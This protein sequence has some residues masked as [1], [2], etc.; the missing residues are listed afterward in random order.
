MSRT[1][2]L[3]RALDRSGLAPSPVRSVPAPAARY[4]HPH[5]LQSRLGQWG[6][7]VYSFR[8]FTGSEP[9]PQTPIAAYEDRALDREQLA[10][11]RIEY[12]AARAM[13]SHARLRAQATPVLRE[14][15][16]LW[17]AWEAAHTALTT[18]FRTFWETPDGRWR[19][20][21]LRL[22][23]AEN[24]A[25]D[26]ARAWDQVA[27][28][29]AA[30]ADAQVSAAGYE[31]ELELAAVAAEAGTDVSGWHVAPASEYGDGVWST[32]TPLVHKVRTEI[33]A[34]RARLRDVA[35]LAGDRELV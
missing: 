17:A 29:L 4:H 14:A 10:E 23:D 7:V 22:G 6:A 31:H 13:W 32:D 27:G 2:A 8:P 16:P 21:L 34:Q 25:R 12:G 20:Q 35:D 15:V 3:H 33:A 9:E 24:A 11:I 19:A 5:F 26:A 18:T 28:K 30:L 1:I